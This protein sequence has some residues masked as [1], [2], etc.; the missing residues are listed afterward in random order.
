MNDPPSQE[1]NESIP[2]NWWESDNWRPTRWA[3]GLSEYGGTYGLLANDTD[4]MAN[5]FYLMAVYLKKQGWAFQS[6]MAV[7]A[8]A[9]SESGGDPRNWEVPANAEKGFGLVQWTPQSQYQN[10]A[11]GIWGAG[12]GWS[13]YYYS[14]WYETYFIAAEVFDYP[15]RQWVRHR[16][17]D[18]YNPAPGSGGVYPGDYPTQ[19]YML[20]YEEFA[21][22]KPSD[23]D[24][25]TDVY[26]RLNY[27]TAA[28]Y[29]DYEQVGDYRAD[30]TLGQRQLR[31]RTW[32]N[33][34]AP[35]MGDFRGH[36][37]KQ[38]AD[39]VNEDTTLADVEALKGMQGKF[40]AMLVGN[41]KPRY[42][43]ITTII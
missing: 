18:G 3:Y 21:L 20:S 35:I 22:G 12:D 5:N 14:G 29:W 28:F 32:Y 19:D 37:L 40:I 30:Y 33:R 24:V 25:T 36:F 11:L 27:L 23:S 42:K 1:Y 8:N 6:I 34:L 10:D 43:H 17:G 16:K 26:S 9:H 4:C 38:P 41:Q 13:P 7:C 15:R 39:P 2:H 31:A